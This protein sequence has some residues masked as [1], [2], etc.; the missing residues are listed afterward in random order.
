MHQD[1]NKDMILMDDITCGQS[2]FPIRV[3][4]NVDDEGVHHDFV[5]KSTCLHSKEDYALLKQNKNGCSCDGECKEESCEC[6]R[7][8]TIKLYKHKIDLAIKMGAHSSFLPDFYN[9]VLYDATK[10]LVVVV[11]VDAHNGLYQQSL[12]L[13]S[14]YTKL[15]TLDL[16]FEVGNTSRWAHFAV[17]LSVR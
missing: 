1:L 15:N 16:V 3:V 9:D 6:I 7:R 4:N 12:I 5:Y 13:M 8:S 14:I 17:N 11:V 2:K 10:Q